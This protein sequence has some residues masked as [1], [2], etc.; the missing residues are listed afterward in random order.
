MVKRKPPQLNE[1]DV[2]AWLWSA[3]RIP[4]DGADA[5]CDDKHAR[6]PVRDRKQRAFIKE[7]CMT[8][9]FREDCL[10]MALFYESQPGVGSYGVW[11]GLMPGERSRL[12]RGR[13]RG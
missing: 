9:P 4:C 10:R 2:T 3:D 11:G 8:C 13:Y 1:R 6:T 5:Y 12:L 7:Y